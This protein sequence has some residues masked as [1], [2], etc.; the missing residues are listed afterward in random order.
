MPTS[1]DSSIP[2]TQPP[3]NLQLQILRLQSLQQELQVQM[4]MLQNQQSENGSSPTNNV[5]NFIMQL[6][7]QQ[8]H[9]QGNE[10]LSPRQQTA[11][12]TYMQQRTA[13]SDASSPPAYRMSSSIARTTLPHIDY[14]NDSETRPLGQ[15][16]S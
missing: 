8:Q 16:G 2:Y 10:Q 4:Q 11:D 7:Q 5:D 9:M 12:N 15:Q 1:A 13:S 6:Q 14:A 3:N